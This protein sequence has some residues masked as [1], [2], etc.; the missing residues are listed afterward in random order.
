MFIGSFN[1]MRCKLI[2]RY[3]QKIHLKIISNV[4]FWLKAFVNVS[5]AC[6]L[7][8]YNPKNF[9][10]QKRKYQPTFPHHTFLWFKIVEII[11]KNAPYGS[12]QSLKDVKT[13]NLRLK[14][15]RWLTWQKSMDWASVAMYEETFTILLSS[16]F[17]IKS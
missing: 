5:K 15:I 16:P 9:S 12:R 8:L 1:V 4:Y 13:K 17:K 3:L 2:N 14:P 6:K 7:Y 10:F 11:F